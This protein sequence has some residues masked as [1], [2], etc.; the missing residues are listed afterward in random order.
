MQKGKGLDVNAP[1]FIPKIPSTPKI[2]ADDEE[3][4]K[5]RILETYNET[6]D[7]D[8][9]RSELDDL[10]MEYV[11]LRLRYEN[12]ASS[13][14]STSINDELSML[15]ARLG[16]ITENYLFDEK[17]AKAHYSSERK[18]ADSSA[19]QKKLESSLPLT[20]ES[21]LKKKFPQ[22][23]Q[24]VP[25]APQIA[26][27][28]VFEDDDSGDSIGVL[29]LLDDVSSTEIN[30]PGAT[31]SLRNMALPKHWSGRTPKTLLHDIV[32]KADRYAAIS[33]NIISGH[34]RAK[35]A[36]VAI[37]WE[38]KKRDEWSMED[39]AC[40]DDGQAEQYISTVALHALSFPLTDGF[41]SGTPITSHSHTFFRLLPAIYR[42]LWEDLEAAR[43]VRDD[44]INRSTWAKLRTIVEG[45]LEGSVKVRLLRCIQKHGADY[46]QVNNK[47]SKLTFEKQDVDPSPP[48]P[49]N[50]EIF[51]EQIASGFRIRQSSGAYQE[52]LVSFHPCKSKIHDID[53]PLRQTQRNMLPIAQHRA[54]ILKI[55]ANSQV[56]VLSGET[57]W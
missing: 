39:V 41:A 17:E 26:A 6:S 27:T 43:K 53:I 46:Q 45:K 44:S 54:E 24:P 51:S 47:L 7:S 32:A 31:F 29:D 5:S 1:A 2:F 52:M 42:G 14:R 23:L 19:L 3:T 40:P 15:R 57:G 28:D 11:R 13:Q 21:P 30:V 22:I 9:E 8:V 20:H 4:I 34:S 38:G 55:L 35:R 48:L 37:L 18:K 50:Q 25:S 49:N 36:S 16:A 56:L 10:T 12:L 33:Y